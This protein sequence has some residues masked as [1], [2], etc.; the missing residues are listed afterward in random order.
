VKLVSSGEV[1]SFRQI[2]AIGSR[3][4]RSVTRKER[5]AL[6]MSPLRR[7]A[8]DGDPNPTCDKAEENGFVGRFL[9]DMR[10]AETATGTFGH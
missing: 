10:C 5:H 9:N 6:R 1:L 3:K 2:N 7:T 8:D 4:F